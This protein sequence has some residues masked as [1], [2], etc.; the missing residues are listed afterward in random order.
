MCYKDVALSFVIDSSSFVGTSGFIKTKEF[1]KTIVPYYNFEQSQFSVI[2]FSD[3]ASISIPF[4]RSSGKTLIEFLALINQ[5]NYRGGKIVRTS[6][7]LS[8]ALSELQRISKP[9]EFVILVTA[10]DSN[11][12]EKTNTLTMKRRL[13]QN[14]A[15]VLIVGVGDSIDSTH[16]RQLASDGKIYR[17]ESFDHLIGS[18]EALR[19]DI[20]KRT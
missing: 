10:S 14:G 11:E 20:C 4:T 1:I 13:E 7:G 17:P 6:E 3:V 16:L 18:V 15:K 19:Q 12:N 8:L 9:A 5:I 2:D